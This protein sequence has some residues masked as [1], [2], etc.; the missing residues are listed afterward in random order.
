MGAR[1][2]GYGVFSIILIL[3]LA[4]VDG[5]TIETIG[6]AGAALLIIGII[7]GGDCE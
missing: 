4:G 3:W 2:A 1:G 7:F 6:W 5:I